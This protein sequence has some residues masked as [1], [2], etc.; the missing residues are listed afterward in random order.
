[1]G[2]VVAKASTDIACA[3]ASRAGGLTDFKQLGSN[4][5]TAWFFE[6]QCVAVSGQRSGPGCAELK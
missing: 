5:L 2:L 3:A 6:S 1:M 4:G